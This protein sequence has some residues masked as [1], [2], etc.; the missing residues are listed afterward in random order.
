[1]PP[2]T[3]AH[4]RAQR[5]G[6]RGSGMA[7]WRLPVSGWAPLT[8]RKIP[9]AACGAAWAL[10]RLGICSVCAPA[11]RAPSICP[12]LQ[13]VLRDGGAPAGAGAAGGA[14]AGAAVPAQRGMRALCRQGTE[15]GFRGTAAAPR[16]RLGHTSPLYCQ[17]VQETVGDSGPAPA[18]ARRGP[19]PRASEPRAGK[20]KTGMGKGRQ[21]LAWGRCRYAQAAPGPTG[22]IHGGPQ[23]H[24][25]RGVAGLAGDGGPAWRRGGIPRHYSQ[26]CSCQP[27]IPPTGSLG[28]TSPRKGAITRACRCADRSSK[29]MQGKKQAQA[30]PR[31]GCG[32]SGNLRVRRIAASGGVKI[33]AV[34][35]LTEMKIFSGIVDR[36]CRRRR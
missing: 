11:L 36:S 12:I 13:G 28:G 15:S 27:R 5:A 34:S 22:S 31:D 21:S 30:C 19:H 7:G 4:G 6:L 32:A 20:R 2:R 33:G 1:M 9:Q 10:R 25:F 8:A 14:D 16:N 24:R 3:A 35:R 26:S 23:L 29:T 17:G 18:L